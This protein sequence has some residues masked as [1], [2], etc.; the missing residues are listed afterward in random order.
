MSSVLVDKGFS[1]CSKDF[2]TSGITGE[3]CYFCAMTCG[4]NLCCGR[5]LVSLRC[6]VHSAVLCAVKFEICTIMGLV[7]SQKL[8]HVLLAH[9]CHCL[10]LLPPHNHSHLPGQLRELHGPR[11]LRHM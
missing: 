3:M 7:S 1:Y 9:S 6:L 2:L 5:L 8:K 11:V 10:A 4:D